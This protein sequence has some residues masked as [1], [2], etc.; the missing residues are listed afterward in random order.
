VLRATRES[1]RRGATQI[2][3]TVGGGA[4]SQADP[5]HT[6]QFTVDEIRA[7]VQAASDWGTYVMV[8]AYHDESVRRA[9]EAGVI[10]I[11]HG[12]LMTEATMKLLAEKKAYLVPQARLFTVTE[13]DKAFFES[14]GAATLGKVMVLANNLDN[15]MNLA[16][17]YK[18]KIGFGTDLFG[19]SK[20]YA[21]QSEEFEFRLKWFTP[22]EIL[23]QATS[24]NAEIV[25][26]SGPLNPY[27]EGPL[28]V[29]KPGAYADLLIVEGNP[30][31]DI[32]LLGDPEKNLKLIMKDGKV[33]KNTL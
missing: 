27:K 33:Y 11:E 17:K 13:K 19:S 28:G 23:K 16:K 20:D 29:I 6:T 1:L 25:A 15:Q 5:I 31:K 8:H 7:G 14:F 21:K 9:L 26:L 30:L 24:M 3:L 4:S 18:V 10:S 12:T 22:V 32:K 2:K